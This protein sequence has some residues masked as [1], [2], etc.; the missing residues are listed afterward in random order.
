MR[1]QEKKLFVRRLPEI[2][3][4]C[5]IVLSCDGQQ[6]TKEEWMRIMKQNLFR[7]TVIKKTMTD[8]DEN[9]A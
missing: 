2:Y 5:A 3:Y 6:Q 8:S 1:E 9:P 4:V 7:Q